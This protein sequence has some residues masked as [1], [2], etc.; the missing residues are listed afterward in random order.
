[1][2]ATASRTGS[3]TSAGVTMVMAAAVIQQFGAALAVTIWPTLGAYSIVCIRF[4][5]GGLILC[6][7]VRPRLKGRSAGEW[8]GV[9]AL[10]MA[11]SVM[12]VCFYNAT[13]RIPLGIAVTI[14][15]LG[16]L[17][18]SIVTATRRIA[19]LW[20]GLAFIGVAVLG[21]SAGG[22]HSVNPVG[23]VFAACAAAAWAAYI[24]ASAHTARIFPSVE[25]LGLASVLAA[26][27]TAPLAI[28]SGTLPAVMDWRVL[29]IVL[30][31]ALM[32]TVVPHSL[33]M[34]SL[35]RLPSSTFAV[36]TSTAPVI[37]ALVGYLVL[38]QRLNGA[39]YV[40]VGLVTT[41]GVGAVLSGR[42]PRPTA[43]TDLPV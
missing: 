10:A 8:L 22:A 23:V 11:L 2:T 18:L 39:H 13:G 32:S 34:L 40:A 28:V 14:E 1:M 33:E 17:V 29:A 16:P 31:V 41:A 19:W 21:M 5:I 4:S 26:F 35:R 27:G 12:S 37:A 36:L 25:A 38:D 7:L 24:L 9:C 42:P 15:V 3:A 30:A 43:L 6:L 20:A